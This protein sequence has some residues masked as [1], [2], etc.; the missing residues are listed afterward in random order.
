MGELPVIY[1]A[2]G[3][4]Q[5]L[6]DLTA[7]KPKALVEAGGRPLADRS[8]EYL[9]VAGFSRIVVVTGHA[10]ECFSGYDVETR[11]NDRW[12]GENNVVSLWQ[13]RDIVATGCVIVNCDLLF[14]P[15]LANRLAA[16]EGTAILVDDVSPVD[17][18]SMK[19]SERDGRLDGL[20][21]SLP[22]A[23]AVG[24]YIGLTRVDPAD[25]P[26]LAE[27]LDEFVAAGNVQVYY[28]DAIAAFASERPVRIERVGGLRWVEIDDHTDLARARDEIAPAIDEQAV[29]AG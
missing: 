11:F 8:F 3:R 9:H 28:E 22:F 15:E 16:A 13:V 17:E 10:A 1:L 21:K 2:A 12:D 7:E 29:T 27:I 25:G 14:E 18:E 20:H 5:R 24:E 26:L 23:D 4:G 6:G 19:A